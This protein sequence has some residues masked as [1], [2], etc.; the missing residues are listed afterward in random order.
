LNLGCSIGEHSDIELHFEEVVALGEVAV[1]ADVVA[2]KFESAE[3]GLDAVVAIAVKTAVD[4]FVADDHAHAVAGSAA[5]ADS[6]IADEE[7]H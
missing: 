1:V 3:F 4:H 6:V 2:V 5:A 7:H